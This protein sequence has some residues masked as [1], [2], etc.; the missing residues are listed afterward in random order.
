MLETSHPKEKKIPSC[1][2]QSYNHY[3]STK[4]PFE[5]KQHFL[6]TSELL[7]ISLSQF[8]EVLRGSYKKIV[9]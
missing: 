7:K 1:T 5:V 6:E 8:C 9:L 4:T 3:Y 2:L